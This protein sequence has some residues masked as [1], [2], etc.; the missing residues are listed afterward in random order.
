[1]K[2]YDMARPLYLETN[3]SGIG[4]GAKLLEVMDGK[5][6]GH[7]ETQQMQYCSQLHLPAKAFL[8][9]SCATAT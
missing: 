5:N 9:Q 4:L 7:D 6:C 1:M 8:V 3:K 2:F